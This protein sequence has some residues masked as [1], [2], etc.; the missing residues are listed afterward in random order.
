MVLQA[1]GVFPAVTHNPWHSWSA[2]APAWALRFFLSEME[3][4]DVDALEHLVDLSAEGP[5]G[6]LAQL[7]EGIKE[8]D[9]RVTI[10]IERKRED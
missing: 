8:D 2:D 10:T 7:L 3:P 5:D 4:E 6:E 1:G 9:I